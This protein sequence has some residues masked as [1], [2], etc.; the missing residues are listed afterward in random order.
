MEERPANRLATETSPYLLQHATNPVNWFPWGDEAFSIARARDVPIFLS[1]GYASC[2][3]C[4]VMERESFEDEGTAAFLNDRFVSIKVDREERPDI[5]AIYMDALQ[6]MTG[7][8]GWP[9]SVFLDW[10]GRPFYAGTYLPAVPRYGMPSFTQVL[11]GIS[12]AWRT[13][14]GDVQAQGAS[15]MDAI[16]HVTTTVPTDA[17]PIDETSLDDAYRRIAETFD[18][19]WGGFGRAPKFPQPPVLGWLLRQAARGRSGAAEMVTTTLERMANGGIHDQVAG[20][21]AR[22]STDD[23]WHVPHFEKML[24]DNA[25]LVQLY[26]ETWL[27]SGE[28]RLRDVAIR[29]ADY[30]LRDLRSP[31]RAFLSSQDADTEGDE[32]RYYVWPYAD[33]VRLIGEPASVALG[34]TPDGNWEGTNVLWLPRPLADVAEEIGTDRVSLQRAVDAARLTL[35]DERRSRV[36]PMLDDKV[37]AGWNGLAIRGLAVAGRVCG[38]PRLIEAAV[39]AATFV[40]DAMRTPSGRLL[41]SWREGRAS[42]RAFLDDHALLGLGFVTLYETVGDERW[43]DRAQELSD[44]IEHRFGAPNGGFFLTADDAEPLVTR[45]TDIIDTAAPSGTAAAAELLIRVSRFT[46]NQE[47]EARAQRAIKP[48]TEQ[49]QAHPAAFAHT[50]NVLDMLVGPMREVAIVGERPGVDDLVRQVFSARHLPN[51]VIAIGNGDETSTVPLLAGRRMID[52]KPTAYV[53]E[54]FTCQLPTSDPTVLA[55]LLTS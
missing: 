12:D 16:A 35:L 3:W 13:R 25:Q 14:R 8:G 47:L 17:S 10:D 40:W 33:L 21:F 41:R 18:P 45:P 7:S 54:R 1:V 50:L 6:A 30:L 29:T 51:S 23:R 20:G 53:C 52:G 43:F 37:I 49:A 42:V 39:E 34:A 2:H 9:M 4:H 22:Y 11:E 55:S 5:D 19:I 36:P 38:E 26:A 31:G 32:G 48:I 24:S 27:V 15:V 44:T 28:P 46:G